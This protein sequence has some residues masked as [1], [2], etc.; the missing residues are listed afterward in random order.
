M[1]GK[2]LTL[3]KSYNKQLLSIENT[4]NR[5]E[6]L[7][8]AKSLD[9][10]DIQLIFGGLFLEV[11]TGFESLIEDLFMG[12]ITGKLYSSTMKR[13]VK[14]SPRKSV[15]DIVF[16]G[17]PYLDWFP[18]NTRTEPMAKRFFDGHI[19]FCALDIVQKEEMQF[20]HII[21]NALAHKSEK[22]ENDFLSRLPN[23]LLPSE[24]T[25][26]GYLRSQPHS[27][28]QTQFEIASIE[29]D[30]ISRILCT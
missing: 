18:Y 27:S 20:Y 11:F 8:S 30:S 26:A 23:T 19:S 29:L 9:N 22:A 10:L 28:S 5:C 6:V 15:Q 12:L 14:I 13:K 21:R 24:K 1:P 25:P 4:R 16:A 7:F 17:K 3:Y 2:T